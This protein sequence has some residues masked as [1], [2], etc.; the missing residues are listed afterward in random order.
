MARYFGL[1]N[2]LKYGWFSLKTFTDTVLWWSTP[3]LSVTTFLSAT[4][5]FALTGNP[6]AGLIAAGHLA[7]VAFAAVGYYLDS[8]RSS[9]PFLFHVPHYF[10]VGHYSLVVGVWNF[11][12][13]ENIVTWDTMNE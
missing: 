3:F 8:R 13:G 4:A 9:V 10:L 12:R 7:L 2:P 5:L 1:L 11:L 6:I